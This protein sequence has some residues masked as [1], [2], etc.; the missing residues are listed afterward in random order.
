MTEDRHAAL[1]EMMCSAVETLKELASDWEQPDDDLAPA[2]LIAGRDGKRVLV[3]IDPEFFQNEFTKDVLSEFVMPNMIR[4]ANGIAAVYICSVWETRLD[5]VPVSRAPDRTEAVIVL[6]ANLE[7][8]RLARAEI[9]RHPDAPPTLGEFEW[10]GHDE[11]H[12][13]TR[14][15]DALL[16]GLELRG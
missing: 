1:D 16:A 13:G 8:F 9:Q 11:G 7:E 4:E 12:R 6:G 2:M 14:F 5:D 10:E 15:G 3:E